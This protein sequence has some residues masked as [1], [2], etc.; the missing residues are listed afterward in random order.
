MPELRWRR[1]C[2]VVVENRRVRERV[3]LVRLA[4]GWKCGIGARSGEQVAGHR[5]FAFDLD[6]AAYVFHLLAVPV[7]GVREQDLRVSST[8][9]AASS[10]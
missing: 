9:A 8:P 10:R 3:E 6:G 5:P 4:T 1:R 7:A 2:A